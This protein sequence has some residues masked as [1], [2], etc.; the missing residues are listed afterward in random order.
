MSGLPVVL[1][2]DRRPC[3]VVGAGRAARW[4]LAALVA[5]AAPVTVIAPRLGD[6]VVPGTGVTV[7]RRAVRPGDTEG[8]GLVVV[9]TDDAAVNAAVAA[10]AAGHGAL[11]LRA[12]GAP[13]DVRLPAVHRVGQLS[14][15]VD[16]GG[17]SPALARWVRDRLAA[18]IPP[19]WAELARWAAVNRPRTAD[20]I[21]RHLA[22]RPR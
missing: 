20:E 6:G 17:S 16:T 9:A 12:D 19:H 8:F 3:L 1:D 5:A 4:K 22:E 11:V 2:V 13:G 14:I 21:D 15:A 18:G 10:E 7:H